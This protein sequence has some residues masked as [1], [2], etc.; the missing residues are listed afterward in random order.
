MVTDWGDNG[1]WQQPVCS[2]PGFLMASQAGWGGA[3][4]LDGFGDKDWI[5]A[6]SVL[7]LENAE[8]SLLLRKMASLYRENPVKLHN[9]SIFSYLL[10]DPGYPYMREQYGACRD[11]GTGG[12]DAVL[13]EC[14]ALLSQ[15]PVSSPFRGELEATLTLCRT[16]VLFATILFSTENCRPDELESHQRTV[17][18]KAL[19][20]QIE[21]F[22]SSWALSS[23]RGGLDE[24]ADKLKAWMPR[25]TAEG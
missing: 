9:G 22:R 3:A 21:D 5:R 2:W 4:S 1:H 25:L 20:S 24:S 13:E 19:E 15:I 7:V 8:A 10:S 23:R 16:G 6:L 14:E 11:A 18:R 12:A 17:L